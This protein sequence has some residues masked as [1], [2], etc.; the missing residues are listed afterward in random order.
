MPT[1]SNTD[2]NKTPFRWLFFILFVSG[3]GAVVL[4]TYN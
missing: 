3:P 2:K 4:I 1:G